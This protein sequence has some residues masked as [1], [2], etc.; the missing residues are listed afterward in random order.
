MRVRGDQIRMM[1][2]LEGP[3]GDAARQML[4]MAAEAENYNSEE[5]VRARERDKIAQDFNASVRDMQANLQ[6]LAI[7][8]LN[9]INGVNWTFFI[10]ILN[11]FVNVLQL[12]L[13]PLTLFGKIL[14]DTGLGLVAGGLL[15][16]VSVISIAKAGFTALAG[17]TG[18]LI[19]AMT[20]GT[21]ALS[22]DRLKQGLGIGQKPTLDP[23]KME[24]IREMRKQG[25][26][27][28]QIQGKINEAKVGPQLNT[29]YENVKKFSGAIAGA[30]LALGGSALAIWGEARLRED[31]ND[32]FGQLLVTVGTVSQYVGVFGG[33]ILQFAPY[34]ATAIT[35]MKAYIVAKGGAIA[36]I[37]AFALTTKV[38][39][40]GFLK[41]LAVYGGALI[42]GLKA[43]LAV[44]APVLLPIALALTKFMLVV[45]AVVLV[46]AALYGAFKLL[47]EGV[48][49]VGSGLM[50]VW[51][52]IKTA[53]GWISSGISKLWDII[54]SPFTALWDWFKNSFIG[55]M[56]GLSDKA[57]D[58]KQSK[59]S[60][61]T[62]VEKT[63]QERE[64][65]EAA[66][67]G[68][69]G[70]KAQHEQ[71]AK[72]AKSGT[73][74]KEENGKQSRGNAGWNDTSKVNKNPDG[75]PMTVDQINTAK[76]NLREGNRTTQARAVSDATG[77]G[78][79]REYKR[80]D[81][82]SLRQGPQG[83]FV[84]PADERVVG[85]GRDLVRTQAAAVDAQAAKDAE[86][87][88]TRAKQTQLLEELNSVNQAQLGVQSRSA[89]IQDNSNR[90]LRQQ[91]QGLQ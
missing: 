42:A 5:N 90:Y 60:A 8:F 63:P 37:K 78:D 48:K 23:A 1:A 15:A 50:L 82:G 36:A 40:A 6:Q 12:V 39:G 7:P 64:R 18:K 58:K 11:G 10:D 72:D 69:M 59:S 73:G 4:Q 13:T 33:L 17:V 3:T 30:T 34:I 47:W 46:G 19:A 9:L 2:M 79:D 45:G 68:R 88:S 57:E 86:D 21:K 53:A 62:E 91:A 38:A 71:F 24:Q 70:L 31:A 26:S 56:L 55:K 66:R 51:E 80:V 16:V 22:A 76:Q 81:T 52:G 29:G 44:L 77:M 20:A 32:T 65:E 49:L 54:T 87:K 35:S 67:S 84:R 61:K 41:T 85:G 14:G 27:P 83:I 28:L 43:S 25:M 74:Y 75:S 89:G